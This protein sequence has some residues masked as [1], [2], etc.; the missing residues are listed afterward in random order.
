M[1]VDLGM[2]QAE[3]PSPGLFPAQGG[4]CAGAGDVQH[5]AQLEGMDQAGIENE[6]SLLDLQAA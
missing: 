5:G 1:V 3:V 2:I 4:R 6:T